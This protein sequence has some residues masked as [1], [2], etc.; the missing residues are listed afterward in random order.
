MM[1]MKTTMRMTIDRTLQLYF[2][3][4]PEPCFCTEQHV[5]VES[6]T[7]GNNSTVSIFVHKGRLQR[8]PCFL[9]CSLTH[10][11][12]DKKADAGDLGVAGPVYPLPYRRPEKDDKAIKGI[13]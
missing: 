12:S 2:L 13:T 5:Q 7:R 6:L 1:K 3:L 11:V 4:I 8:W 10:D 9:I